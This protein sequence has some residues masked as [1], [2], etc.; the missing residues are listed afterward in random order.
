MQTISIPV[1]EFEALKKELEL[2][3]NSPLLEKLNNLIDLLYEEKYGLYMHDFTD[4]M[5]EYN[6]DK[7]WN[8][9]TNVWNSI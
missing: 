8:D 1:N 6:I 9:D 2:L 4:D 5:T 3:R 7:S